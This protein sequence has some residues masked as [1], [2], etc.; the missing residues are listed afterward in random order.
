MKQADSATNS[1]TVQALVVGA[2]NLDV[3]AVA[4][5]TAIA[6]DSTPGAVG[7]YAGGVGRNIAEGL[8]RLRVET[9]LVSAVG[10]DGAG[11]QLLSSCE[12]AGI[13]IDDIHQLADCQTSSY[14]AVNDQH[15]EMLYA[16]S[17]MRIFDELTPDKF[18]GLAE[19]VASS[20]TCVIDCNLPEA[21]IAT[22][23]SNVTGKLIAD[24]VSASKCVRLKKV[25]P[26][27]SLLKV[28]RLEAATLTSSDETEET[29]VLLSKLLQAGTESVLMTLGAEG[30][31]L[32]S[33]SG[34]TRVDAPRASVIRNVNGA[35]DALLAGVVAAFLHG[36]AEVEA[37][38]WGTKAA[39]FSLATDSACSEKM[40][41]ENMV[42]P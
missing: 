40:T 9:R 33:A 30:A 16:I 17:D 26:F 14:V 28:N 36:K 18:P 15:G 19:R 23:V 24:A 8:A 25:L 31:I 34:V 12:R 13:I 32:A 22:I 4:G 2:M 29:D 11:Q 41:L 42:Y 5:N 35:G 37:L 27:I 3:L 6:A 10:F 39:G 20:Q 38:Q 7:Y 21:C 1:N